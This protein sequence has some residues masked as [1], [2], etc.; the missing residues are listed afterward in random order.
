MEPVPDR[1]I[2]DL[3]LTPDITTGTLT[4]TAHSTTARAGATVVI[5]A[6]DAL[7]NNAGAI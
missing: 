1:A 6:Y 3:V 4:V 2:D 5:H 7:G